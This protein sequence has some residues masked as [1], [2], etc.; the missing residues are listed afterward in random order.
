MSTDTSTQ[1]DVQHWSPIATVIKAVAM[2]V[3]WGVIENVAGKH[4]DLGYTVGIFVGILCM[5]AVPPREK[6]IW[7]WLLVGVVMSIVHPI[8]HT[9]LPKSWR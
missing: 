1:T 5:C 9:V 4:A 6:T 7:R 8:L 2:I 3:P